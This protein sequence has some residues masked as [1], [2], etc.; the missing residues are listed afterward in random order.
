MG[1]AYMEKTGIGLNKDSNWKSQSD[2]KATSG[3]TLL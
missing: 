3:K 2:N 1:R